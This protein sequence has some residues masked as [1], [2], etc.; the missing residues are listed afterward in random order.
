MIAKIDCADLR[1][2]RMSPVAVA[3]W[4]RPGGVACGQD[5]GG[6]L[7]ASVKRRES[8]LIRI[9]LSAPARQPFAVSVHMK[10]CKPTPCL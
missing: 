1:L 6:I 10:R 9:K 4:A 8:T 2:R 3:L 7:S 5:S